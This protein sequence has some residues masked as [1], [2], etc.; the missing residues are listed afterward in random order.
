MLVSFG[1][2]DDGFGGFVFLAVMPE[3]L[4]EDGVDLFGV[5]GFGLVAYGFD[6]GADAEVFDG[7]QDAFAAT[8]DEVESGFGVGVMREAY[9]VELT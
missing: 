3:G 1:C 2:W 4:E 9:L 7:S 8:D 5:D 6:H